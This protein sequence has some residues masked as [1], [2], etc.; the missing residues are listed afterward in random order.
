[1]CDDDVCWPDLDA[2]LRTGSLN[3]LARNL[4]IAIQRI[5]TL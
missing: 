5:N 3:V 4:V 1:M 2:L